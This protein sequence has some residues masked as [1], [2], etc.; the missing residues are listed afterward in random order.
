[1]EGRREG[2]HVLEPP[3]PRGNSRSSSPSAP[4]TACRS[5]GFLFG[6]LSSQILSYLSASLGAASLSLIKA[7]AGSLPTVGSKTGMFPP[8]VIFCSTPNGSFLSV[9]KMSSRNFCAA[10]SRV[11]FLGSPNGKLTLRINSCWNDRGVLAISGLSDVNVGTKNPRLS[12]EILD[13]RSF[14]PGSADLTGEVEASSISRRMPWSWIPVIRAKSLLLVSCL[15]SWS[16]TSRAS[17]LLAISVAAIC[18]NRDGA[19]LNPRSVP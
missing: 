7:S 1:M 14:A 10:W 15:L 4:S 6:K 18:W 9:G 5:S 17:R 11:S 12:G 13:S 16:S 3:D 8:G 19:A 2:P